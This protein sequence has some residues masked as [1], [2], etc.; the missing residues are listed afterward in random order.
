[1]YFIVRCNVRYDY[2]CIQLVLQRSR[3][4]LLFDLLL[5]LVLVLLLLLLLQ[6][7]PLLF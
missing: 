1:M 2:V 7:L 4:Q 3:L 5:L 6:L